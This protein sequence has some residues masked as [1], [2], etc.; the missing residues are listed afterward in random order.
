VQAVGLVD[1]VRFRGA[2]QPG[3]RAPDARGRDTG[4][5]PRRLFDVFRGPHFTLLLFT[6]GTDHRPAVDAARRVRELVG[7]DVRECVV[8][9]G[10]RVPP[11]REGDPVL[12]DP[13]R[14]AH[15]LY[16]AGAGSLYLVRP[17]GYVGFRLLGTR[18]AAGGWA[19]RVD[20]VRAHLARTLGV[21]RQPVGSG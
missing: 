4:G 14:E 17:D 1:R 7:V 21:A 13:D 15:R 3:D 19:P 2:P 8:V 5:E 12:L 9:A 20:A 6:G 11:G 16:G 18:A 10:A